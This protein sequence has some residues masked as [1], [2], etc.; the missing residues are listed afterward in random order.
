MKTVLVFAILTS[1]CATWPHGHVPTCGEQ[2]E[3]DRTVLAYE[4]SYSVEFSADQLTCINDIDV[5][6]VHSM[7]GVCRERDGHNVVGQYCRHNGPHIVVL[8]TLD[9]PTERRVLRHEVIHHIQHCIGEPCGDHNCPAFRDALAFTSELVQVP[10][11][12][13]DGGA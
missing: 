7:Q 5:S 3:I 8:D 10:D 1:G 6:Y 9:G 4:L 12:C 11:R 13:A 2:T